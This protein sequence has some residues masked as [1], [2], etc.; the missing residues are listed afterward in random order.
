MNFQN[1]KGQLIGTLTGDVFTKKEKIT[2]IFRK[3]IA[4][5]VPIEVMLKAKKVVYETDGAIFSILTEVCLLHPVLTFN[6]ETKCYIPIKDWDVVFT[7]KID[8]H[9][10]NHL[11]AEWYALLRPEFDKNYMREL[12]A[13]IREERKKKTIYPQSEDVFRAFKLCGPLDTKVVIVGQD[14]YPKGQADGLAFSSKKGIP[15]SLKVIYNAMERELNMLYLERPQSLEY[16]ASQGV[17]L[18]NSSLTVEAAR[19]E[20]HVGK[21]WENFIKAALAKIK[22]PIVSLYG[23]KAIV[24]FSDKYPD[25]YKSVHPAAESYGN[26][27]FYGH[28]KE[29]N[30]QL[31]L[32]QLTP[33]EWKSPSV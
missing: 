1:S 23:G 22:D 9:I 13:W 25:A 33:I 21:G 7:K 4:W 20:S 5:S 8:M 18:L 24:S 30:E 3:T 16:L 11:G 29:I 6:G 28:Y 15:Y 14:P 2:D 26:A 31:R 12:L 10:Y 17:L 27:K 19:P 32:K